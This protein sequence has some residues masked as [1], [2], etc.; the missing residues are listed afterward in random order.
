MNSNLVLAVLLVV[1]LVIWY[2]VGSF[3]WSH[4]IKKKYQA[5]SAR[6][7]EHAAVLV[8]W[9]GHTTDGHYG[10]PLIF[11]RSTLDLEK[12]FFRRAI[13]EGDKLFLLEYGVLSKA[14]VAA[15]LDPSSVRLRSVPGDNQ[16]NPAFVVAGFRDIKLHTERGGPVESRKVVALI[17]SAN[18]NPD[19]LQHL[20][21]SYAFSQGG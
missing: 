14:L 18:A 10:R 12:D 4:Q 8:Q 11:S 17:V 16:G 19:D 21:L 6:F 13:A 15:I 5:L 1:V 2:L 3:L 7:G 9:A 20:G